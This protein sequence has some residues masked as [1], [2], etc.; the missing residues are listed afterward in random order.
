VVTYPWY[1]LT[2]V[3]LKSLDMALAEVRSGAVS[4]EAREIIIMALGDVDVTCHYGDD[5]EHGEHD[6][7]E[8][9]GVED[10][11]PADT[12]DD[13]ERADQKTTETSEAVEPRTRNLEI[14]RLYLA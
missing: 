14:A 11:S 1:E 2:T 9:D 7:D 13:A 10:D 5:D 4:P 3:G 6:T 12:K 8:V